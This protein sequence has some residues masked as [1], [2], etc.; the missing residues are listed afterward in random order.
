MMQINNLKSKK[1]RKRFLL[2]LWH[3]LFSKT[4]ESYINNKQVD[5]STLFHIGLLIS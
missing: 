3:L 2:F 5:F 1:L 4:Y